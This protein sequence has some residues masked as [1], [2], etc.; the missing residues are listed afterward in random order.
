MSLDDVEP[1]R[2][3]H[4][5]QDQQIESDYCNE[6]LP[7]IGI[8]I[9]TSNLR[10][11]HTVNAGDDGN[12]RKDVREGV[13]QGCPPRLA[14]VLLDSRHLCPRLPEKVCFANEVFEILFQGETG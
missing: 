7:D 1:I 6:K 8:H 4:G 9:A 5:K 2:K 10:N 13:R 12:G 3:R 14:L 11:V